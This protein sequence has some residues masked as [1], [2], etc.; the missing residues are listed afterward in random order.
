[1]KKK[2]LLKSALAAMLLAALGSCKK[3]E[4][5]FSYATN[6]QNRETGIT[7]SDVETTRQVP[8][9]QVLAALE[10]QYDWLY[11]FDSKTYGRP[12]GMAAPHMW[13]VPSTWFNNTFLTI[14][15]DG[16]AHIV[17]LYDIQFT[18]GFNNTENNNENRDSFVYTITNVVGNDN[19]TMFNGEASINIPGGWPDCLWVTNVGIPST[20][21]YHLF[22]NISTGSVNLENYDVPFQ[23]YNPQVTPEKIALRIA[24]TCFIHFYDDED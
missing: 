12:A 20:Y 11:D 16:N 6:D 23:V 8:Y 19:E 17:G 24:S 15:I 22:D 2:F 3:V 9:D 13:V 1:M 18:S 21:P 4:S 5:D 10:A 14:I 7:S